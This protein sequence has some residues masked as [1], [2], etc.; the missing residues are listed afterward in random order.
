MRVTTTPQRSRMM[1]NIR[2]GNTW[3]EQMLRSRLFAMGF[4]YRLHARDLPGTPDLVF[5]KYGAVIFVHGCFWHRH[6]GCRYTTTPKTNA[7]FWAQKFL[8][9]VHRD[10]HQ[11]TLL[12]DRG[13]RVAVV[14]ECA[15]KHSGDDTARIVERWLH[16][17]EIFL[18]V[19]S[20][21]PPQA[22]GP[23]PDLPP[24]ASRC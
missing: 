6:V 1:S 2:G 18:E 14:W 21:P 23:D 13:W 7:D 20:S 15:L 11:A 24:A 4:R 22:A 3:P 16:G 8:R 19:G 17:N 5:P 10:A 12:R 9:N